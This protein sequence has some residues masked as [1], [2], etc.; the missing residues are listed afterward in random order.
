MSQENSRFESRLVVC[1][2]NKKISSSPQLLLQVRKFWI[3]LLK[4]WI[5]CSSSAVPCHTTRVAKFSNEQQKKQQFHIVVVQTHIKKKSLLHLAHL[6]N[7]SCGDAMLE[8]DQDSN[9]QPDCHK[10]DPFTVRHKMLGKEKKFK[11]PADHLGLKAVHNIG[12]LSF[13]HTLSLHV[14]TVS[15]SD[16]VGII[17]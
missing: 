10:T 16:A 8:L 17:Y 7:R 3:F 6:C 1:W 12:F 14:I 2:A 9:W 5:S 13:N 15:T 11:L 4:I